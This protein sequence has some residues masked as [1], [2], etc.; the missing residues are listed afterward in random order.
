M[1]NPASELTEVK[2]ASGLVAKLRRLSLLNFLEQTSSGFDN[3]H[4]SL[5]GMTAIIVI[6]LIGLALPVF[7]LP[8]V[9]QVGAFVIMVVT[10][11]AGIA[12]LYVA[13]Y[14]IHKQVMNQ[15]RLTEVLV[16]SLGQGFLSFNH[17]GLCASVYSQACIDLL[18]INP[19]GKNVLEVL[20]IP[21]DQHADF[22]DWMDILFMPH[23]ALSFDDVV[24]FLPQ[25]FRHSQGRR[26]SLMYRPIRDTEGALTQVVIIVTDQTE[27]FEAQQLIKEQQDFANMIGRIFKER[28][29]FYATLTHVRKFLEESRSQFNYQTLSAS[30]LRSLHTLKAAV[31]HFH[32]NTLGNIISRLESD[33]RSELIETDEDFRRCLR[34]GADEIEKE[35]GLVLG[36]VR[37]L[38]GQDYEGRGNMHEIE[39]SVLYDFAREMHSANVDLGLIQRYLNTVAAVPASECM[40]LFERELNDLAEMT[41]KQIKPVRFTGTNPRILTQPIHEFL[42]SLAHISRNII[43]HGIEPSVTRLARGKDP[44]G[45]ITI[46]TDIITEAE[47]KRDWLHIVISDDGNGVD[48][49][50][51]R[52]KLAIVDPEGSWP[53]EDDDAVI[54]R[55]FTWG[56]STRDNVTEL[57]GR[58][59]GLEVVQR[60]VKLLGGRIKVHSE[61][62]RGVKFDIL[63]PYTIDLS[64]KNSLSQFFAEDVIAPTTLN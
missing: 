39:E 38:I 60:E 61:L 23:H 10:S 19:A 28:N 7:G 5:A 42:F 34:L 58:G 4:I 13:N 3:I 33:L 17:A 11:I 53:N 9:N 29:Q 8:P 6:L 35:L 55:I 12:Y 32:L 56:F 46:H 18:E 37:D 49:S 48:P 16:N 15:S 21:A 44:A 1:S 62:Y 59:V 31:K 43:D 57:S 26:I 54:Q 27:E 20:R 30:L 40:R 24:T 63:I 50:K 52:A 36:Q 64:D 45:Q 25:F 47:T 41:G 51:V 22:K 2:T 14:R